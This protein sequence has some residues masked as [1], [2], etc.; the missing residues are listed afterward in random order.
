[1]AREKFLRKCYFYH[2]MIEVS[3]LE[4][5][6]KIVFS[7]DKYRFKNMGWNSVSAIQHILTSTKNASLF[8]TDFLAVIYK[9]E[10]P[11]TASL[12]RG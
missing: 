9:N 1:M 7:L 6:A 3:T 10:Q 8:I 5:F 11:R 4:S 12:C 2:G